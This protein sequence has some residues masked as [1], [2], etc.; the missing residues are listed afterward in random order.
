[1]TNVELIKNLEGL[2]EDEKKYLDDIYF[3]KVDDQHKED[4]KRAVAYSEYKIGDYNKAIAR[5]KTW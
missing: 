1:M 2:L 4:W 5:L 3:V